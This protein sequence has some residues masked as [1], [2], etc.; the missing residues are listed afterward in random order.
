MEGLE[1]PFPI[2]VGHAGAAVFDTTSFDR[3][4]LEWYR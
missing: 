4:R 3:R 1:D 2:G